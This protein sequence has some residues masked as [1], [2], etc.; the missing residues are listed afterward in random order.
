MTLRGELDLADALDFDH[1][2][3]TG[4]QQLADLGCTRPGRAPCLAVGTLARGDLT[5]GYDTT[6]STTEPAESAGSAEP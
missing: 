5:L 4:A 6:E 3:G 1:A 2:L